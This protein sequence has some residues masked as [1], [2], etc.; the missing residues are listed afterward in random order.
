MD[1]INILKDIGII[2]I[3]P[4]IR[5]I[6]G[7]AVKALDDE[8]ISKF[9]WKQLVQTV[10]RVGVLGFVAYFGLDAIGVEQAALVAAVSAFV[11]DKVFN[12]IKKAK[13]KN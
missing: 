6:A 2:V 9:E 12:A 1:V 4:C 3:L 8:V 10:V 5:S 7:W 13:D 11:A